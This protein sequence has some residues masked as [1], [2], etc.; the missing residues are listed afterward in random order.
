MTLFGEMI[1]QVCDGAEAATVLDEGL[2]KKLK[3]TASDV[4]RL[5]SKKGRKGLAFMHGR[6]QIEKGHAAIAK[7]KSLRGKVRMAV[8][9]T[10]LKRGTPIR[11]TTHMRMHRAAKSRGLR[12]AGATA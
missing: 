4:A 8:G 12:M 6:R 5:R 3:R 10:L 11:K 2:M 9:K 7:G 1:Q